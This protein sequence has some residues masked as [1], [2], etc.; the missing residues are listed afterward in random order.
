MIEQEN[1]QEK[2]EK[3]QQK[4][5]FARIENIPTLERERGFRVSNSRQQILKNSKSRIARRLD[6]R[7]N[8][9]PTERPV[10][11]GTNND[12][13]VCERTKAISCGGIGLVLRMLT[14]IGLREDIDR[15][16]T[17][18][19]DHRPYHE[20]DHVLSLALNFL[21]GGTCLEDMERLRQDENILNAVGA[22]RTPAPT[23]AAD[24]CR[25]FRGFDV[26]LLMVIINNARKRVWALQRPEFFR[27]A[28]IDG[29]GTL[30][31]TT[32]QCKE[33][34]DISYKGVWGYHPL[35]ISLANTG[36]PLFIVNRAGNRPSHE[37][38]AEY[39]DLAIEL[40]RDAGFR[41]VTLRGDTDFSQT[42]HLDR[43]TL[44][45]ARFVFGYDCVPN[46]VSEAET[47]PKQAWER[48]QRPE[49]YHVA[50]E[51]RRR[52]Q[53]VKER[54]IHDRGFK[55]LRL[56]GEE[57]AEFMYQPQACETPYRMVVLRKNIAVEQGETWLFDQHRYFFYI[58]N[59]FVT[60][61]ALIVFD[62]NQRCNQENLI[63]E[64][65]NGVRAL[66]APVN[67]LVSNW[68]YMVIASLAWSIKAWIAL[69]LPESGPWAAERVAEKRQLLRSGFR[70]FL[71]YFMLIPAQI[72]RQGR[73]IIFRL[74]TWNPQ[75]PVFFRAWDRVRNLPQLC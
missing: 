18:F 11:T 47:L 58:T 29:D 5:P 27:E 31:E 15:K 43:W 1:S 64:L 52:P 17:V 26:F 12:Y 75:L 63:G 4:P 69:L 59:D 46:L 3:T 2:R 71:S 32:G 6:P 54:I 65:K 39:F 57:V 40:C 60:P 42:A 7:R 16:L 25:R 14:A 9:S 30:T 62:A 35:L 55:N 74:L 44:A 8:C 21:S 33:G 48:L 61:A 23:T 72:V 19:K 37:R 73:K 38:A 50:T 13:E 49:K 66:H 41:E 51:P 53:N 68:A 36:E 67:D 20:S 56:K 34:M 22:Q 28:V 10:L 70:W 45:G 24:F